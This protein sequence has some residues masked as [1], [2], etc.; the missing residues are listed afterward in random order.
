M[1]VLV[2]ILSWCYCH[3]NWKHFSQSH[4]AESIPQAGRDAAEHDQDILNSGRITQRYYR[5]VTGLFKEF[6]MDFSRAYFPVNIWAFSCTFTQDCGNNKFCVTV[7]LA[8]TWWLSP[9]CSDCCGCVYCSDSIS[10]CSA[11][12]P[13][14]P[15]SF[16]KWQWE[17]LFFAY[18]NGVVSGCHTE[19]ILHFF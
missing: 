9:I 13:T 12:S 18:Q 11:N 4:S 16:L 10:L 1:A 2:Q 6:C 8:L 7:T 5:G 19:I 14:Y 15:V 3:S 17:S